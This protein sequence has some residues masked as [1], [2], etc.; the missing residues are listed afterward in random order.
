MKNIC[1]IGATGK[2]GQSIQEV[3][4]GNIIV[5]GFSKIHD[6]TLDAFASAVSKADIVIDFSHADNI[7]PALAVCVAN[8]KPY[9]CGTTNLKPSNF[10]ALKN[11]AES[12]PVMYASNTSFGV[13]VLKKAVQLVTKEF[14]EMVDI[15]IS[16]THHR[17][18]KDA[19]SGTA[20]SLGEVVANALGY[21]LEQLKVTDRVNNPRSNVPQIGFTSLRGGSVI[22]EHT[23]H[24]F[25]HHEI[26]KLSHECLDR[27]VFAEGAV[28][29]AMWLCK[30]PK[31]FYAMED[32]LGK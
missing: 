25:N 32:M 16:E 29:A 12:I 2:M 14:G 1:L 23:V 19:P 22:G 11:A 5:N 20:I 6:S 21:D 18:K 28:K 4:G 9:F 31:G 7:D 15:E 27:K 24:F 17:A 10:E 26:I 3:L 8:K 13:A 30:Q